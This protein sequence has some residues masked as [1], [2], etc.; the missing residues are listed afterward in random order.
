LLKNFPGVSFY[1]NGVEATWACNTDIPQFL[2]DQK[3]SSI[4]KY[5][6]IKTI[7]VNDLSAVFTVKIDERYFLTLQIDFFVCFSDTDHLFKTNFWV[8]TIESTVLI[9]LIVQC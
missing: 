1:Q 4:K 8:K 2:S 6:E 3:G 9:A 7:T 5:G